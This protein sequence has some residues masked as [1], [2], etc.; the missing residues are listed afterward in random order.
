MIMIKRVDNMLIAECAVTR[1]MMRDGGQRR[2]GPSSWM[3]TD[4][5]QSFHQPI[6]DFP[7]SF[8]MGLRGLSVPFVTVMMDEDDL[9]P[10][11]L[12]SHRSKGMLG[13]NKWESS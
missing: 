9:S 5:T 2:V 12:T 10:L 8:V 4:H 11:A 13:S 7:K 1:Q 6:D 3:I